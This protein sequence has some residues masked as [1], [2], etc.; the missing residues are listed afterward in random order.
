MSR[1]LVAYMDILG[2]TWEIESSETRSPDVL[3]DLREAYDAALS[4]LRGEVDH[5]SL[6]QPNWWVKSFTDDI[7]LCQQ[8]GQVHLESDVGWIATQIAF[9]QFQMVLR[10]FFLR[11]GL[12]LGQVY[13]DDAI[14]FGPALLSAYELEN[15]T[16]RDPRIVIGDL[17]SEAIDE[18]I[19]Y[20]GKPES[21]PQVRDFLRDR[22]G[23]IFINYLEAVLIAEHECGPYYGKL[24]D[25]RDV[26]SRQLEKHENNPPVWSKY[27]WVGSYHN[28]FCDQY[29]YFD[30]SHKVDST[31][32]GTS[33]RLILD[34]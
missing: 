12:S 16:A 19:S 28:W 17:V 32:F 11:G 4:E 31:L 27:F 23:Q 29:D 24:K 33:P 13:V 14:V 15:E 2:F 8:T 21:A 22:D 3:L 34:E 5:D 7:V 30:N 26:V 20:Y 25:H 1:C 10:G 9:F 18:H 6:P